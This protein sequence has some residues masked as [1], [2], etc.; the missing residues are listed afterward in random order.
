MSLLD[1]REKSLESSS[2]RI[3]RDPFIRCTAGNPLTGNPFRKAP[4]RG[5]APGSLRQLNQC[6]RNQTV[7]YIEKADR[8]EARALVVGK[9]RAPRVHDQDALHLGDFRRMG[10]AA[11]DEVYRPAKV[12]LHLPVEGAKGR[13][14]GELE[15]VNKADLYRSP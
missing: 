12:V 3:R 11:H 6:R 2:L 13:M 10:A 4:A 9:G 14:F 15:V 7:L 8:S 1:K 5:A